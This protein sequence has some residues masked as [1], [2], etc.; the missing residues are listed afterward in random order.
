[1]DDLELSPEAL[2]TCANLIVLYCTRQKGVLN[3]YLNKMRTL[4]SEWQ[5]EETIGKLMQEI[6]LY[7]KQLDSMMDT[8][9]LKYPEYFR[10]KAET[11]RR[12]PTL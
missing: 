12:R 1:M 9:I 8:M 3:D 4:S 11:I 2:E 5:D 6:I 10:K 7:K